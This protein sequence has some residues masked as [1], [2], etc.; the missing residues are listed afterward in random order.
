MN[1]SI[2]NTNYLKN[3]I[4]IDIGNGMMTNVFNSFIVPQSNTIEFIIPTKMEKYKIDIYMGNNILSSDNILIYSY[5][6][7]SPMK[8]IYI[9]FMINNMLYINNLLYI[10]ISTKTKTLF[11]NIIQFYNIEIPYIHREI[12]MINY[13]LKFELKECIEMISIKIQNKDYTTASI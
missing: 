9:K 11:D 6:I 1:N 7:I 5:D 8:V 4:G 3:N 12:D 2:I 13:K 10:T